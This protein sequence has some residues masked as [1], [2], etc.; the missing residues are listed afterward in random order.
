MSESDTESDALVRR[1]MQII[2]ERLAIIDRLRSLEVELAELF[3]RLDRIDPEMAAKLAPIRPRGASRQAGIARGTR[4][5]MPRRILAALNE[6]GGEASNQDLA[7]DLGLGPGE[8]TVMYSALTR[9]SKTGR[10]KRV[11]EGRYRL[12]R[13]RG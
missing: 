10:I 5:S 13:G 12:L 11:S 3:G 2:D 8:L 4:Q 9:L 7:S 6:R 1:A